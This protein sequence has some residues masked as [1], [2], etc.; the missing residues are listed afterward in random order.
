[1][2][3]KA[4]KNGGRKKGTPNAVTTSLRQ[5]ID[6]FISRNF[7]RLQ[8]EYDS[9]P[10]KDK[11]TFI[12]QLFAYAVPKLASITNEVNIKAKLEDLTDDQL[13]KVVDQILTN[14]AD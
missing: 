2:N 5:R 1:M 3:T 14:N 7:E 10:A 11:L 4:S 9:L 6:L 12:S 13:E 8:G